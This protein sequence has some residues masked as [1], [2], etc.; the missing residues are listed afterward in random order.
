MTEHTLFVKFNLVYGFGKNN[1]IHPSCLTLQF[2][3]LGLG[4]TTDRSTPT[5]IT[6]IPNITE[7]SAGCQH[8]LL[9]S[10]LGKVYSFGRN[11]VHYHF[12]NV[13]NLERRTWRWNKNS[14]K[15]P[16]IDNFRF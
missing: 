15:F 13:L 11:S 3:Q 5:L 2:G 9:L 14:K 10:S 4:D 8:S 12:F 16:S 7:I 6:G 1:V